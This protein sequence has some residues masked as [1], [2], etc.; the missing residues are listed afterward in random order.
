M[1]ELD[2][3]H[4]A[5]RNSWR[6]KIKAYVSGEIVQRAVFIPGE[7]SDERSEGK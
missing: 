1:I 2:P 4:E 3:I 5:I 6:E 7:V